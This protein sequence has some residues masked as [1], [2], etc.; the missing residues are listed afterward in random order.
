MLT[1]S[2]MK[3]LLLIR[4]AKSSWESPQQSDFDRPLNARGIKDA[5]VMAKKLFDR[6]I[7]I[8]AFISS[9]AVRAR[10]T[11]DF[12]LDAFGKKKADVQLL[13]QL[14]LPEPSVLEETIASLPDSVGTVAIFSHN[15]GITE[16]ANQL[17]D[18]KID[19]MPTCCIFA[20]KIE[21]DSWSKFVKAKKNFWFVDYPKLIG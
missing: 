2:A 8:D 10:Q 19:N 1:F 3:T 17:T 5:P 6:N 7:Q 15:N 21:T 18:A 13:S 9:P 20:V 14:Y 12:F 11:C 4:H 16:F